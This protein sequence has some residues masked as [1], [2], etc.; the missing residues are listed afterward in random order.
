MSEPKR[1]DG[2]RADGL[3]TKV[4]EITGLFW[5]IKLLT[6]AMGEATSDYAVSHFDPVAAVVLG[7]LGLV[8]ALGLQFAVRRYRPRIYWLVVVMV[9]VFGTMAADAVH[10]VLGVPYAASCLAFVF[11]LG[12][13]FVLW[14]RSERSLSIHSIHTRRREAFYWATVLATF[15][16]GT[17]T[18][19]LTAVTLHLGYLGSGVLFAVL[20]AVPLLGGAFFGLNEVFAFWGAYIMTR[21]LGASFAD[22]A[23]VS[24]NAGGLGYGRGP[25]SLALTLAIVAL[26]AYAG[27]GRQRAPRRGPAVLTD[28]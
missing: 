25:V 16:L 13:I 19:D 24:Q 3:F 23:G 17:A 9:S 11:A 1:L 10:V 2:A 18:G 4:P 28:G 21:P 14:H 26:V 12:V 8:G 5:V 20:F 22:W 6:T 15:A 7:G 27:L